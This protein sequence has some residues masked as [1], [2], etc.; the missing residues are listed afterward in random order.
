VSE[1]QQRENPTEYLADMIEAGMPLITETRV[2]TLTKGLDLI[3]GSEKFCGCALGMA[4]V[5]QAGEPKVAYETWMAKSNMQ[6][7]SQIHDIATLLGIPESLVNEV[8]LSHCG[9]TPAEGIIR[10]LRRGKFDRFVT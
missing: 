7:S 4:L 6:T 9:K 1:T 10:K 8:N 2:C 5:G 3:K